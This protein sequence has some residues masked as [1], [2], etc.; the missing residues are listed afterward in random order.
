MEARIIFAPNPLPH[1]L[2][3]TDTE[4]SLTRRLIEVQSLRS[5]RRADDFMSD[6]LSSAGVSECATHATASAEVGKESPGDP[7]TEGRI[8][9]L[10][11]L[12]QAFGQFRSR[13][14]AITIGTT[15]RAE[16]SN[17]CLPP[18]NARPRRQ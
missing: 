12:G 7:P 9:A 5:T 8:E 6:N 1:Y 4:G 13:I 16:R 3:E 17:E 18:P 15:A 11:R 2:H 10:L 14:E